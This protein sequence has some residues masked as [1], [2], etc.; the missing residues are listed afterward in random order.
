MMT[1]VKNT[2]K[3]IFKPKPA[4]VLA[5]LVLTGILL[6]VAACG[7]PDNPQIAMCHSTVEKAVGKVEWVETK[8]RESNI[9]Q[10]VTAD[11][12]IDGE[13]G[14]IDCVYGWQRINSDE[15]KWATAPTSV[16]VNGQKM[17]FRDLTAASFGA[18][19]DAL[20]NVASETARET[21]RVAGEASEQATELANQAG[22]KGRE[23]A[24]QA[25]DKGRELATQAEQKGRELAGQAGDLAA[26]AGEKLAPA[27][28]RAGEVA[29]EAAKKLQEALNNN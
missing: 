26:E 10:V 9:E 15:G 12:K 2:S 8:V 1:A 4:K 11:Y 20:Q 7:Q 17:S 22:D 5:P 19:R 3:Q 16:A 21:R 25:G 24:N 18:S 28:Q 14:T 13:T 27:A 6:S 29:A 23:L